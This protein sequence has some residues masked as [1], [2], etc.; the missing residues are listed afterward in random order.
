MLMQYWVLQQL[1]ACSTEAVA[2]FMSTCTNGMAQP[3]MT[4][5]EPQRVSNNAYVPTSMTLSSS[6]PTSSTAPTP[7][8]TP[9]LPTTDKEDASIGVHGSQDAQVVPGDQ[10]TTIWTELKDVCKRLEAVANECAELRTEMYQL[11][12]GPDSLANR[13][14]KIGLETFV[15]TTLA[16]FREVHANIA[17]AMEKLGSQTT[18]LNAAQAQIDDLMATLRIDAKRKPPSSS[19]PRQFYHGDRVKLIGLSSATYNGQE[20]TVKEFRKTS[21]RYVVAVAG[22]D[23]LVKESNLALPFDGDDDEESYE[24]DS[25]IDAC[26]ASDYQASLRELQ[27]LDK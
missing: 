2:S 1:L 15:P 4:T 27:E 8:L 23:I 20:A 22:K 5:Y 12:D 10:L 18:R 19:E 26:F 16:S 21:G 17:T 7:I 3:A 9:T 11:R 6:S 25:D 14:T 13:L 24:E